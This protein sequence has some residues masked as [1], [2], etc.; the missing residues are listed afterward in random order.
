MEAYNGAVT[1]TVDDAL[2]ALRENAENERA[3]VPR[4]GRAPR[5]YL[6]IGVSGANLYVPVPGTMFV[7]VD[8]DLFLPLD[9]TNLLEAWSAC[10]GCE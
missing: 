6:L 8:Y 7:T 1:W 2:R 4:A 5:S 9:P 10:E 3:A